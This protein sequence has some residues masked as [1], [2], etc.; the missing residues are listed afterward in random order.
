MTLSSF[1][2]RT[3]QEGVNDLVFFKQSNADFLVQ[4]LGN[5]LFEKV[6]NRFGIAIDW[7][8]INCFNEKLFY[9]LKTVL[10]HLVDHA[11]VYNH[12]VKD[13]AADC[14]FSVH[15]SCVIDLLLNQLS[16]D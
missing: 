16:I 8:F 9:V 2:S 7:N 1:D 5:G 4:L 10:I 14:H 12:E 13:T 15:I 6:V 3:D 11:H